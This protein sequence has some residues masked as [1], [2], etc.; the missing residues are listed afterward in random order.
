MD[1]QVQASVKHLLQEW[2]TRRQQALLEQVMVAWSEAASHLT[3]DDALLEALRAAMPVPA[4]PP[5]PEAIPARA[6]ALEAALDRLEDAGTQGEV[7]K[8]LLEGLHPFAAR[9]AVFVIKQGIAT[10]FSLRG[11][12]GTAPRTPVVPPSDLEALLHGRLRV[13]Q[14]DSA[15]YPALLGALAAAPA[16]Q[17][18]VLPLR[19]RR[20]VVALLLA[21]GGEADLLAG[22]APVRALALA[23]EAKLSHLAGAKEEERTPAPEVHPSSLTQRIPEPI[24]EAAPALDPKVRQNAER[25]ARVLVGDIE[26]YFPAKVAQGQ[27]QGNLYAALRDELDRSRASFVE[28]YGGDL[29]SQHQIF[30]NTVVHQLCGGDPSRLGPAPWAASTHP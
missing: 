10:L 2:M 15:A 12:D 20:K 21:D 3:P 18:L 7:L 8:Q 6:E 4:P 17:A 1:A 23:A 19:L 16:R 5:V 28:R 13:L 29:E 27:Q 11:F 22:S 30:Y 9:S 26:L 25:S 14:E 24:A